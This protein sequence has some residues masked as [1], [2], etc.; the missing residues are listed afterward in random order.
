ML[1]D[2]DSLLPLRGLDPHITAYLIDL[3]H[4]GRHVGF[5]VMM[6]IS[7]TLLTGQTTQVQEVMTNILATQ[8]RFVLRS[9]NVYH[10]SSKI[11]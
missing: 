3:I 8:I 4:E 7:Y 9:L 11:E 5:A 6:Q 2:L 10:L 1:A